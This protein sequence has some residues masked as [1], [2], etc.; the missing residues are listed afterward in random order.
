MDTC[1]L[2]LTIH[3]ILE[4][5]KTG[6]PSQYQKQQEQHK[7]PGFVCLTVLLAVNSTVSYVAVAVTS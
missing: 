3:S 4:C 5:P 1:C 6:D 2:K 7:L